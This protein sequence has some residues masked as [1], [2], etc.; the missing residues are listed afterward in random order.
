MSEIIFQT[1]TKMGDKCS[2][3]EENNKIFTPVKIKNYD[4]DR[5]KEFDNKSEDLIEEKSFEVTSLDS[6]MIRSQSNQDMSEDEND[7]EEN[8]IKVLR[9]E[10]ASDYLSDDEHDETVKSRLFGSTDIRPFKDQ[11]IRRIRSD[12]EPFYDPYFRPGVKILSPSINTD[13]AS[14]LLKSFACKNI[15][16]LTELDTLIKWERC[17][18][19]KKDLKNFI[20]H[21]YLKFRLFLITIGRLYNYKMNLYSMKME[22][23]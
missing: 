18:V 3:L 20:K 7:S 23:H 11:D 6:N 22:L 17:S 9:S 1:G 4:L 5:N 14:S 10:E 21:F 16:D 8:Q 2:K 12:G 19:K 15:F 13:L